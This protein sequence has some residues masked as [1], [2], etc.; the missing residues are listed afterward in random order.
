MTNIT[1]QREAYLAN[2]RSQA[3][4]F[5]RQVVDDYNA[6]ISPTEIAK[7]YINPKTG[8]N[9]HRTTIHDIIKR[10]REEGLD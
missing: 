7:R 4:Q 1:P 5:W 8:R 9:Y 10:V 6:G 2:L 3:R